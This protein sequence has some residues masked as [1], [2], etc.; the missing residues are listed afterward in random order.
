[1]IINKNKN[2][3]RKHK[4]KWIKAATQHFIILKY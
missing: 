3:A 4:Y 2:T 1:M